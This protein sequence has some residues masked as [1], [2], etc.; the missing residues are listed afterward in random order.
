MTTVYVL[1]TG[2]TIGCKGNPLAPMSG[3]EFQQLVNSLPGMNLGDVSGYSDL[4]YVVN[5][6]EKPLDSSNMIPSDW[7]TIANK[8]LDNYSKYDGFVILHGTDTMAFTS[9]ALSFLLPGLSKPVVVTGSQLP[10]SFT[11]ND[12]I[13][14]LVGSIVLAGT[15][16]IPEICLYFDSNLLRGNRSV[17]VN[18]NRFSAFE[19][20]NYPVLAAVGTEITMNSKDI[21]PPPPPVNSLENPDNQKLLKQ[22]LIQ[23][24][25]NIQRFSVVSLILYP[26]IDSSTLTGMMS[27]TNPPVRGIVIQSFGEGNGPTNKEFLSVLSNANSE[28]IVLMDNTQVL[29]GSVNIGAYATGSGLAKAGALSSHDMTPES[30]LSKLVY[31]FGNGFSS[32]DVK[33][34]MQEDIAGEITRS[35]AST[36]SNQPH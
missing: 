21:L 16:K 30:S 11:L 27:N 10:L 31:L 1:Y 33:K 18:A 25:E 17:K 34:M 26:G 19:S 28:G 6:F 8:I 7:I 14:N 36:V 3:P 29:A 23:I 4:H 15:T 12:A 2:G 20:P 13:A 22:K 5:S 9:S 32:T 35:N 24:S